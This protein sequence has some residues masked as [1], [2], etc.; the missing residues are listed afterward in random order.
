MTAVTTPRATVAT[1][2]EEPGENL[3]VPDWPAI[4]AALPGIAAG[5]PTLIWP[6]MGLGAVMPLA[7]VLPIAA[8]LIP[9]YILLHRPRPPT[10]SSAG[11]APRTRTLGALVGGTVGTLLGVCAASN[12]HIAAIV[13]LILAVCGA[14]LGYV[15]ACWRE[16][17]R[18]AAQ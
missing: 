14:I 1:L 18:R 17:P 2:V 16:S 11:P 4:L 5:E 9:L 13:V 8:V 6:L 12:G 15:D 10:A 3:A 7:I